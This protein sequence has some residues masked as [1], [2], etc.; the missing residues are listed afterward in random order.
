MKAIKPFIAAGLAVMA[1]GAFAETGAKLTQVD[2][3][4]YVYGRANA[5]HVQLAGPVVSRPAIAV[6]AGPD[7]EEGPV[8]VAIG[9]K[10]ADVNKV[11]GRS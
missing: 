5:P 6:V 11:A 9:G 10:D 8:A 1:T 7:T 3:V 4:T 2:N